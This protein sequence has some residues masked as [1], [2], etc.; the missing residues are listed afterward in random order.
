MLFTLPNSAAPRERV[1][2]HLVDALV[3]RG[4][5]EPLL[6]I[7]KRLVVGNAGDEVLQQGRVAGAESTPLSDQPIAESRAAIDLQ[8][9]EKISVEQCRQRAQPL[10]SKRLDTLMRRPGDLEHIDGA[11][12]QVEL[13]GVAA[14]IDSSPAGLVDDAPDLAEA[15][16]KL[17]P[18]VVRDVPQQL[19]QLAARNGVRGKRKIG[20]QRTHLA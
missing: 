18:R 14:R 7:S 10:R 20:D 19:A 17:A 16:A 5:L 12:G 11:I 6:Q 1:Q 9:V 2:K 4:K 3:E 13:D 15:P 8:A